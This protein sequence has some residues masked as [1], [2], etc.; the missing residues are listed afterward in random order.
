MGIKSYSFQELSGVYRSENH[1]AAFLFIGLP[2]IIAYNI[3]GVRII[4]GNTMNG[5]PFHWVCG[6]VKVYLRI[7]DPVSVCKYRMF[8]CRHS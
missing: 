7:F 4:V 5:G 8:F 1:K 3:C 6:L 2:V